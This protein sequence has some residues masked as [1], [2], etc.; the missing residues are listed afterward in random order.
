MSETIKEIHAAIF[1][2]PM[3]M[4]AKVMIPM[5][6]QVNSKIYLNIKVKEMMEEFTRIETVA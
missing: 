1:G 3:I 5:T 4:K 6:S 2:C